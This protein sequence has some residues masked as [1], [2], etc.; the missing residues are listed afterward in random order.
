MTEAPD[1]PRVRPFD[2]HADAY[3]AWFDAHPWTFRTEVEALRRSLPGE[4]EVLEVGVG[5]GRFAQALGIRL[6]VEPS[7]AMRE[8]AVRRG[9]QAVEGVAEALPFED[10]RFAAVLF[11]TTFCFVEDLHATL[12]EAHRVLRPGGRLVAGFVDASSPLGRSYRA[13]RDSSRFYRDA[14][15]LDVPEV[16]EALTAAGFRSP[17]VRRTL[18]GDP[19]ARQEPEAVQDPG[20][21]GAFVVLA[22]VRGDREVRVEEGGRVETG[23]AGYLAKVDLD[24]Q[25]GFDRHA[26]AAFVLDAAGAIEGPVLDV[27]VGKGLFTIEVAQRGLEVV[28]IDPDP[29]ALAFARSLLL[30][31]GMADRVRLVQGDASEL[32]F[33]DGSFGAVVSMNALHHLPGTAGVLAGMARVVRPGG[34][35]VLADLSE[36]GMDWVGRSHLEDHRSA[37]PVGPVTVEAAVSGLVAL[38]LRVLS[39]TASRMETVAVLGKPPAPDR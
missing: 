27:G 29:G 39:R 19:E 11:V 25:K 5:T 20:G 22:A 30:H 18:A 2:L 37:H 31:R 36:A 38:G 15:F 32:P 4:G 6:G 7:A 13:R 34:K 17:E 3:E 26:E 24:R 35:V 9:V 16:V 28:G 1:R 33:L 8:R 14:R 21:E 12:R 10:G 23:L